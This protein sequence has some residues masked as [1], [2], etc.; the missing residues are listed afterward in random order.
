MSHA[1]QVGR[2]RTDITGEPWGVGMMGYGMP[3]QRSYGILSRQ[4]ARAFVL[5]AGGTRVAFVVADIGMYFHAAV[6]EIHVRL[7]ERFGDL[8]TAANVILTAT[9][10]HCGPG[11]HGTDMLYNITTAGFHTRTFERLV[12]GTVEAI[13]LAH[14]DL[15]PTDVS[16]ATGELTDASANRARTAFE[17]NPADEK[18]LFPDGIDPR[19]R[20]L[21]FHRDGRFV[22]AVH[23]FP[24]HNTSMPN[25]TRFI[26]ADN[27]GRA[28]WEW[29]HEYPEGDVVTAF[30]QTNAGDLSPNLDLQPGTGPTDDPLENTRIIAERQVR[31]AKDLAAVDGDVL[32]PVVD[33]VMTHASVARRTTATGATGRAILGASFAAGKMTDGPGSP[34]FREGRRNP[35]PRFISRVVFALLPRVRRAHAPKDLFLPIGSLRWAQERFGFQL[36]RLG[37]LYLFSLPMEV[38]VTAGLRLRRAIAAELG[39]DEEDVVVQGY[40]NGYGHYVTTPQEYQEQ[41]YE[42]GATVFGTHE[43][44]ALCEIG[45]GL[46]RG[47]NGGETLPATVAHRPSRRLRSP[48]GSPRLERRRRIAVRTAPTTAR[49]GDAVR[50]TFDADHPNA[51]LRPTYLEVERDGLVIA[52]DDHPSTTIR[53]TRTAGLRWS[54]E[55]TWVADAPGDVTISYVGRTRA[56][57]T[58][59]IA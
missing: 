22:G 31:S 18:S 26:S 37:H 47:L 35:V 38:T 16:V 43:L 27:K 5:E 49:A 13:A 28:A 10:T 1:W 4:Y 3:D 55:V 15:Q 29:E 48:V 9:H 54:A 34:L 51:V 14:E 7:Q 19:T 23:W 56:S 39:V 20:L 41:L 36:V 17:R 53:W 25:T 21:R 2:A 6:E 45:A 12:D 59:T 8:Y 24:V 30:A 52:R 11:G 50:V 44:T 46:A 57:T 40:A 32:K 33:V 58:V 42:G